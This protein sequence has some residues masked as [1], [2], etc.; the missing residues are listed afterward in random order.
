MSEQYT[1]RLDPAAEIQSASYEL[2]RVTDYSRADLYT[3]EALEEKA[4]YWTGELENPARTP[5]NIV[6]IN[7]IMKFLSFEI[8]FRSSEAS[9]FETSPTHA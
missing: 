4:K 7:Q 1:E 8:F 6:E 2:L 9:S 5:K 3:L